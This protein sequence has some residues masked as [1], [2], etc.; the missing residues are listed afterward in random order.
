M[1][2][3]NGQT[4]SYTYDTGANPTTAHALLSVTYPDGSHDYFS[5]DAQ[6]RLAD[7]HRDGGAEDTTFSYNEGQV[8][9]SDALGDITSY[10]FDNRGLLLRVENP[11]QST[12]SFVYDSNLN[13]VQTI[14]AAGQTYTNT[15]DSQGNLLSSTDPLGH[16]VSYTYSSIDDRL[17]SVTDA[18]GNTTGYHYDGNGNL[19]STLY[20]NGTIASVAYDPIGNVLSS[21]DQK[22]QATSY[23]YDTAGNVLTETFADGS[24]DTFT[25]DAH[26]NLTSATDSTGTTTLTYDSS[27]QLAQIT[28]PSGRYL[29]YAYDAAGQ[30]TQMVDQTGY[31]VDY[32]YDS[33]GNLATLTDGS[34]NL[35]AK[36]TYDAVGR[37]AREDDGNGTYTTY[38]YDAAGELLHLV[39]YA[40]NGTVNSRFDYTYDS[41][42][43]CITEAT[44]DGTWTYSY[45]VIGELT[46]AVFVSTNPAIANQDEAYFYDAAGNRTQTIINGVTTVYTTNNMNEYTQVGNTTYTY[47]ADGNMTSAT[48]AS[49]TTTYTF[50]AENQLTAVNGPSG[51]WS[52]QYDAFGNRVSSTANG[53]TTNYVI[54]PFG[55][56]NVVGEYDAVGNLV[57]HYNYGLGLVSRTDASGSAVYYAFDAVGSTSVL[58]NSTGAIVNSYAYDPFGNS[59]S[60]SETVPN[61]FQYVGEYGVTN[62]ANGLDCVRA[63][64]LSMV[65][66]RFISSDP[67][68]IRGVANSYAYA[69][70]QPTSL[71]DPSGYCAVLLGEIIFVSNIPPWLEPWLPHF[72]PTHED[73]NLNGGA[74]CDVTGTAL[75]GADTLT[76][77]GGATGVMP[78]GEAAFPPELPP[79]VH[80]E[81]PEKKE[82]PET[83]PGVDP[84]GPSLKH[85]PDSSMTDEEWRRTM[86]D[87]IISILPPI[88]PAQTLTSG[89]TTAVTSQDPNAMYGPAGYGSQGFIA[90]AASPLPYRVD[91]E[92]DPTATAPA[93]EVTVTDQLD[94]SL[95]WKTLEFTAVGFGDNIISIPANT[96]YYQ[97]RVSMTYNDQTFDVDIELGLN[98]DTGEVY[99]RFQSIDPNT[100]LPPANVLTGFLPP[101]D[102]TGRGQGYFSY[103]VQPKANLPTGTQIRNVALVSFDQGEAIAT[104]Q[105]DPYDPSQGV[106]PTKECLNTIDA[107]PPT[108]SV[109]PLPA[110]ET[111]TSFTVSWSGT[112]DTGGSGIA[113]YNVYISDNDGSFQ[114]W[115]TGT[116]D[117]S[118][119]FTGQNGHTYAFYSI[120]T[121]NVGNIEAA[122]TSAEATTL[123]ETQM[124]TTITVNSNY[125][126]GSVYGQTVTFT[127]TVSDG[128]AN[129]PTGSVQFLIDGSE[130]GALVTLA[131]GTASITVPD[132]GAGNYTVAADYTS[133]SSDFSG[134]DTDPTNPFV[135]IVTPALLTVTASSEGM[136][137]GGTVPVLAYTYTGL[138]NGDKS[139][140]FTGGLS[141]SA[142][143]SSGVGG[144]GITQGTLVATGNYTIDPFNPGTLTVNAAPLTVTAT[145][146]GMT[147]GGTVP[148]LAYTYTGLVNGDKSASF[149]GGLSTS[150]SSSSGVG[151]YGITQGTLVATGNYTIDPFNPGTLTVNAAPLTVT[152]TSEGMTYGGTVPVLAY[153]YTGLVNG[154]KSAPSRAG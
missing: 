59:L 7:A 50:D 149:T 40:P 131:D 26:E 20:A 10:Y 137:Y 79:E 17:A 14:D 147:Y 47:D 58:T 28:Y 115:L 97:T 101:E 2:D 37:L 99:A 67:I 129:S 130:F 1:V 94:P 63:R 8:S 68:G 87:L 62:E 34:G 121:D 35:I 107:G 29:K 12:V 127:A 48:D 22:G 132:L 39:N 18:N 106:D 154:D 43:Q 126:S 42:G 86:R 93:Q 80:S 142:S 119:T 13:L 102:G 98:L 6:G 3:F 9:V 76:G 153:T 96:Q 49:G 30:R 120:A 91:F 113:S 95:D 138:V 55:L 146:E 69:D 152:A 78:L 143:S 145:S 124:S 64:F 144:Y 122:P 114:P 51:S 141:T 70:N 54:D 100:N 21:T 66:G 128:S 109:S 85:D 83:D 19:T 140:S 56:G 36:Y 117:T 134:S 108:S 139:A 53:V 111:T 81:P 123:L 5:Y 82:Q 46:H 136:T 11:L 104:D 88:V 74:I 116:T 148:T 33:L 103:I 61:P 38:S 135:Q 60:K 112:D 105:V 150:A 110:T 151:G 32:T 16:T 15:Y 73:P 4:T 118:A 41:L 44:V 57:A 77:G 90:D 23:T 71:I 65:A 52:Y 25:Y 27:D 75:S 84:N 125:P 92:N 133:D 89:S 72:D 31:T 45:D 24:Q